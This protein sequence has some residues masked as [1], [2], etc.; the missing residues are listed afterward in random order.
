MQKI[1]LS[2][3]GLLP[4]PPLREIIQTYDLSAKSSLGQ[5]FIL[6]LN[7]TRKIVSFAGNLEKTTV[8]EVGPGPGGLTRAILETNAKQVIA[9]EQDTRAVCALQDLIAYFSEHLEVLNADALSL[10]IASLG[11]EPR[12]IIANL[13][14]N[15]ATTLLFNWLKNST[16]FQRMILMF[17]KEVA[18]RICANPHTKDYGRLAIKVQWLCEVRRCM[19]LPPAAFTPAPKVHSTVVELIPRQKPLYEANEIFLDKVVRT[20]FSKRRKMIRS[21]LEGIGMDPLL[22]LKESQIAETLRPENITIEEYC[23]L[24]C[25][26]E[27][28]L[29]S[30]KKH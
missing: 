17:Q 24:A 18:D 9:I 3:P 4:L 16:S 13:P 8:I 20:A 10:D 28:Y 26:L 12:V 14:Y 19:T 2:N 27:K 6:D 11:E 21:A 30:S 25:I 29:N 15:I 7:L 22:L 23:K 1:S 5:N